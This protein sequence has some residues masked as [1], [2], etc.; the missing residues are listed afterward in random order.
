VDEHIFASALRLDETVS[1]GR[2]EPFHS[3]LSH[4]SLR[5]R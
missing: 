3:A 5:S 1:F 4:I 2:V